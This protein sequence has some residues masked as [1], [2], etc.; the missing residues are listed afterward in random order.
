MEE[1]K[2]ASRCDSSAFQ[3]TAQ[4]MLLGKRTNVILVKDDV[5]RAKP[6]TR[7]L[8]SSDFAFGKAN[9]FDESAAD[10]IDKFQY[11]GPED[12]KV[13]KMQPD[14]KDF[15]RLN[16]AVLRDGATNA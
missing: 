6:A 5:G 16:K 9:R 11:R 3:R 14:V 15:R 7:D 2:Q 8:P 12:P 10:V 1:S 4:N 13:R